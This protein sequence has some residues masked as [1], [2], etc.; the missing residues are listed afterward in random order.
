M[1]HGHMGWEVSGSRNTIIQDAAN[2]RMIK[3]IFG[4][5]SSSEFNSWGRTSKKV[6]YKN[7]PQAK[8]C[9]IPLN[10]TA[11]R[12][13]LISITPMPMP[14]PNGAATQNMRVSLA[15]VLVFKLLWTRLRLSPNAMTH[16][17][18]ITAAKICKTSFTFCCNPMASPS[19]TE[20]RERATRRRRDLIEELAGTEWWEWWWVLFDSWFIELLPYDVTSTSCGG[21]AS[22]SCLGLD[23]K[24]SLSPCSPC[25]LLFRLF[26]RGKI[27]AKCFNYLSWWSLQSREICSITRT[28]KRPSTTRNSAMGKELVIL[29]FLITS[30]MLFCTSGRRSSKQVPKKTPPAKQFR[31][32]RTCPYLKKNEILV[33]NA[34]NF[35][36]NLT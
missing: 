26:F 8:P 1:P 35:N 21:S 11:S 3:I 4:V 6:T 27:T 28:I 29:S 16:L 12:E 9:K 17:C 32:L 10:M 15:I 14:K 34:L 22:V 33:N 24:G 2:P 5:R 25:L 23:N 30:F 7:V 13:L 31:R 19:K 20:W 36:L 18:N